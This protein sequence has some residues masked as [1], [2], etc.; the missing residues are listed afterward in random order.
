MTRM[1]ELGSWA[2]FGMAMGGAPA[3][4]ASGLTGAPGSDHTI[5]IMAQRPSGPAAQRPSGPAAQRPSGPA[6]QRHDVR[7]ALGR[8]AQTGS[9]DIRRR[10]ARA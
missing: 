8:R 4:H 1:N 2:G 9:L 10:P 6:A 7:P 5:D 3:I